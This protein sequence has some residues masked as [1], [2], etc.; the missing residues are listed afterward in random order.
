MPQ[1]LSS[2]RESVHIVSTAAVL[3]DLVSLPVVWAMD[4]VVA[5]QMDKIKMEQESLLL[6]IINTGCA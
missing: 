1:D 2:F 6:H 4:I 3:G 5:L